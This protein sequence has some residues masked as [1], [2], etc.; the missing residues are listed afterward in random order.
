MKI[1]I[2]RVIN[3]S[4][5]IDNKKK[6][7][8]NKGLMILLGMT[9]NDDIEDINY[10]VNKLLNLRIF[11]KNNKMNLNVKDINGDILLIPQFTL[12]ANPYEG[13]R[14]SFSDALNKEE[15][16][17]L[18]EIFKKEILNKYLNVKFGKFGSDMKVS[19]IND[20]PVTIIIDSKEK[21]KKWKE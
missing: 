17:N 10:L 5:L 4:V 12:Y 3:S 8:I 15:A 13:N 19:L 9:Y 18:F 11:E 20:G 1:V 6:E 14:P 2:Q 16:E 21:V 7:N